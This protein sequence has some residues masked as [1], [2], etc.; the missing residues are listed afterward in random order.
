MQSS[1]QHRPPEWI[2]K[3]L[4]AFLDAKLLEAILG[5]LEE[6]FQ[7]GLRCNIPLWKIKLF[8]VI[9]S[10]GFLRMIKLPDSNSVQT[11]LNM[12]AH[13]FL[14]FL[15][16]VRKDRSY[17]VISLLGLAVSLTSFLFITMF[18]SH[19]LAYDK[20]HEKNDRIVRV[21]THLQLSDV[22]YHEATSQFPAAAALQSELTEVEHTVRI[23]PQELVLEVDDKKF[24]EKTIFVDQTFFDVFTFPLIIGDHATA[25]GHPSSIVLT[26]ASAKKYFGSENPVGKTMLLNNQTL[27]VT[28]VVENVPSQSHLKFDAIIPLSYQLNVWKKE[29]GVEGRENKWFWTGAYTYV[30]LKT[31]DDAKDAAAKLS[32]IVDKYFPERYKE[33]GHFRLQALTDIHLKSNYDAE[34]EPG[35]S[36]LYVQLFSIVAF[37]I[38]IVSTI[39]L[40]NLSYFKIS[41]RIREVGIRKFLGQNTAR[42]VAQLSLESLLMGLFA[43]VIALVLCQIFLS[44]FNVLVQKDI[45]LWSGPNLVI[46]LMTFVLISS[47][48]FL[49]IVQPALRFASRPSGYL[50]LQQDRGFAKARVRNVLI[51]LQVGFSFVL[52]V[53]S[54]IISNQIDFF[55]HSDLGFD[56]ENIVI[57]NLNDDLFHSLEAFKNE[58]KAS[59]HVVNVTG[60]DI[61]GIGYNA[62]RFVPEG[63]SYERPLMLPF[64]STDYSFLNTMKINLLTGKDFDPNNAYD[65]IIPFIIN[66]RAA[67]ELGWQENPLGRTMEVFAPG[68]TEIMAKGKVIG[69]VDDYHFESLHKPVKPVVITVSPY[70]SA[71]L[72]KLSGPV[73]K[74]AINSIATTWKKFS[75]RPFE[76]EVLDEKLGQLY[77]NETQLSHVIL[78]FTFIALYLTCYGL[79]AMSSLLFNSKLKEVAIRKVFGADQL[80]IIKQLY[81]RYAMFNLIAIVVGLP[82]AIYLG[83]LWLQTFQYKITLTS[84]FFIKPAI[85]IFMGGL[86]SV[87]YYLTRV[88]FSNPVKFLRRE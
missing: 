59:K 31:S 80:A 63:G 73:N 47:I 49:S 82:I 37:V 64:T 46:I 52:L 16:L 67:V 17:Y 6:K 29:T 22:D 28:G 15:R 50:L 85:I 36:I 13:T 10:V 69:M 84:E 54:F 2:R 81:A 24:K 57:V 68:T 18:I 3:L 66:K 51:G 11:T 55:K 35:G 5:D 21:T 45:Q 60:A 38:M 75:D 62:W 23:F 26:R 87:S 74:N 25:L 56:K 78:F 86:V 83:N 8:Y 30:L 4:R 44:S 77:S 42:I 76:Y 65:S 34:L 14:F 27:S 7:V 58:L 72:I 48:C 41:S 43:F 39:N 71:A 88:A 40:I 61:P 19:E 33:K 70:Y 53:F 20:F 32:L 9:E 1:P 12:I 79:F